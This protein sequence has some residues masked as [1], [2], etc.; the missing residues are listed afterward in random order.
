MVNGFSEGVAVA[1]IWIFI[2][3]L[4]QVLQRLL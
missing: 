4:V 3:I 2:V 1:V